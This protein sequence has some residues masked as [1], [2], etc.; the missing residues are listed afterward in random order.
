MRDGPLHYAPVD[1]ESHVAYRIR[2]DGAITILEIGSH[3]TLFPMDAV[4]DQPRWQRFEDRLARLGRFVTFDHR[5]VGYSDS[6]GAGPSLD[7]WV[8]DTH[9]V[10]DGVGAD[11]CVLLGTGHGSVAAIAY[12]AAHPDRV[13]SLI[14]VNGFARYVWAEDYTIGGHPDV[15]GILASIVEPARSGDDTSDIDLMAP[16]IAGDPSARDWWERVSRTGTGPAFAKRQWELCLTADVRAAVESLDIPTLV[17]TTLDNEFVKA[18]YGRW[19]AGHLRGAVLR[20]LPGA[21][22]TAWAI[23]GDGVVC[24]IEEFLTGVRSAETGSRSMTAIL[25]TDIVDSTAR[26]AEVG[27][28]AWLDL[29]ASHDALTEREVGRRGGRVVKRLGDGLLATFPL[30]SDAIEAGLHLIHGAEEIGVGV[31]AAVHVAEVEEVG[32]DVLGIGVNIA[33]RALGHCE[34]AEL[35]ATGVAAGLLAGSGL[36]FEPRGSHRLKGVPGRWELAAVRGR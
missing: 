32:D 29:L 21:D 6:V 8:A 18:D 9:A 30:A 5:G 16:S 3:G 33:A 2:G 36:H 17:V 7:T 34:G 31:R 26:N 10:A 28:E 12:A 27:D 19:I 35:V 13:A 15:A 1:Q 24:E 4:D 25:F 14:L 23:P 11:Q 22:H 20:E